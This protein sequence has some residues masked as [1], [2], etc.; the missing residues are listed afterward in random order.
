MCQ[1]FEADLLVRRLLIAERR[2]ARLKQHDEEIEQEEEEEEVRA[3]MPRD[4]SSA[5]SVL[6]ER[7]F[8]IRDCN[9]GITHSYVLFI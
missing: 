9:V 5:V 2:N 6:F 7:V 1:C 4:T 3:T 8:N